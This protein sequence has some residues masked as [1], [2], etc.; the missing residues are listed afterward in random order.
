MLIPEE[1]DPQTQTT[2]VFVTVRNADGREHKVTPIEANADLG[3]GCTECS[4]YGT[5]D[6]S[7]V[8]CWKTIWIGPDS[9]N[10]YLED[11]LLK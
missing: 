11:K 6:C 2:G 7:N 5:I 1:L 10:E 9:F 8:H 3:W 4:F